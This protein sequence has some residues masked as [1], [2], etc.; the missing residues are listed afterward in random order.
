M[1]AIVRRVDASKNE[2]QLR[3]SKCGRTRPIWK[4]FDPRY[5]L[6]FRGPTLF[7][8]TPVARLYG[9]GALIMSTPTEARGLACRFCASLWY[10]VSLESCNIGVEH[11]QPIATRKASARDPCNFSYSRRRDELKK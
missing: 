2:P 7:I 6:F 9:D 4:S 3:S 5:D 8:F 1:N 10:D 11:N